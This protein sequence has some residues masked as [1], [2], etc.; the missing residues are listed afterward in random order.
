MSKEPATPQAPG[1][2]PSSSRGRGAN[3]AP[4]QPP[5]TRRS[6]HASERQAVQGALHDGAGTS[7]AM[8]AHGG[9]DRRVTLQVPSK[10]GG[11]QV[12]QHPGDR[13]YQ[14]D[15]HPPEHGGVMRQPT[16]AGR[17]RPSYVPPSQRRRE[18]PPP[19]AA[20]PSSRLAVE[21]PPPVAYPIGAVQDERPQHVTP[22]SQAGAPTGVGGIPIPGEDPKPARKQK[23]RRTS[24]WGP[25]I[26]VAHDA[27]P[28]P[29]QRTHG[30]AAQL[31]PGEDSLLPT[32]GGGAAA[33]PDGAPK[34]GRFGGLPTAKTIE[35]VSTLEF[36]PVVD[37]SSPAT[38]R[39][40]DRYPH[41]H[42]QAE[43]YTGGPLLWN[44]KGRTT[45]TGR[46]SPLLFPDR[47]KKRRPA[48][49]CFTLCCILFWLLVVG[50][51]VAIL[52]VYLL[53]HPQQ[54]RL[55]VTTATLNAG[56][57][58]QLP[59]PRGGLALNSDLYVLA[60][61]YNPNTKVDVVMRYMQ[62]D[63]YFHGVMIGTQAV[64]PMH[65]DPGD[66]Q[67][68][69]VHIVVSEVRIS[70]DDADEWHSVTNATR[71]GGP[72]G[73]LVEMELKAKFHVQLN[74]GRWLPFRYWVYPTC[75][76][77]LDPPPGGALRRARCRKSD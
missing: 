12:L 55:R 51:G 73:G 57:V 10:D 31:P 43:H 41:P 40:H 71:Y 20:P 1:G 3:V 33:P 54:P 11:Q 13:A 47:R 75:S 56:Y 32:P 9:H 74:F 21:Q 6:R 53:Y 48:A 46:P 44:N 65:E 34:R 8:A 64:M 45:G 14:R 28:R 17:A 60:A 23:V 7:S 4:S 52:V 59:P 50:I 18:Q 19:Y 30:E 68:R 25:T 49:Y 36:S 38:A 76:L 27:H 22:V 39:E 69:S 16:T 63:L 37:E 2:E 26:G 58:D 5:G 70:Q 15:E 62:L 35:R 66:S 72:N 61:I 67:L 29:H 42:Q 24:F 77:W